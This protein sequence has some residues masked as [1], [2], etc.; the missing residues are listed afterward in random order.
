MIPFAVCRS[1]FSAIVLVVVLVLEVIVSPVA[2]LSSGFR[3]RGAASVLICDP[4]P[5]DGNE[6]R[7]FVGHVLGFPY[8][9]NHLGTRGLIPLPGHALPRITPPTLDMSVAGKDAP[10]KL[11]L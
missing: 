6:H 11:V 1:P 3:V 7:K 2:V 5:R 9:A 8:R 4:S 10:V